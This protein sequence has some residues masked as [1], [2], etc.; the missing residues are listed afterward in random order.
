M[1][2]VDSGARRTASRSTIF[3]FA[4]G[5]QPS[6]GNSWHQRRCAARRVLARCQCCRLRAVRG[7]RVHGHPVRG[8]LL[9]KTSLNCRYRPSRSKPSTACSTT[10]TCS[11]LDSDRHTTSHLPGLSPV[12]LAIS[13][14][15]V[16]ASFFAERFE[17][18]A[19]T[20]FGA[21]RSALPQ[22]RYEVPTPG[23]ISAAPSTILAVH[24][25]AASVSSLAG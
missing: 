23:W 18:A 24:H 9:A 14:Q 4:S 21:V 12:P 15:D 3:R 1:P 2:A 6:R 5:C 19:V 13:A 17:A 10:A 20:A 7:R 11:G 22:E 8:A 25:P 16:L